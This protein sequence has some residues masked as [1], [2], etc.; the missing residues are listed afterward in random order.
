MEGFH[1]SFVGGSLGLIGFEDARDCH[2]THKEKT[3]DNLGRRKQSFLKYEFCLLKCFSA[4]FLLIFNIK[5]TIHL[6]VNLSIN[7]Y[8]SGDQREQEPDA[9][10]LFSSL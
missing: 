6:S 5:D 1:T 9:G 7:T 4:P 2:S 3:K 8:L 10:F